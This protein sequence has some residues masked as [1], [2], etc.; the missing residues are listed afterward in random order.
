MKDE[1]EDAMH[2]LF[3]HSYLLNPTRL[4]GSRTKFGTV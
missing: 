1:D 3:I 2:A 4:H